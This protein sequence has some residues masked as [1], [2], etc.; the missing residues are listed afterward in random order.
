MWR[1]WAALCRCAIAAVCLATAVAQPAHADERILAA[2]TFTKGWATFGLALPQ[3]A[4]TSAV[5]VGALPTQTDVK[6][7]WPDG[8]IRFAVV[9][10]NVPRA[11]AL[12]I[13][14]GTPAAGRV[15][16]DSPAVAV[17]LTIG[18]RPY[19]ATLGPADAQGDLWLNGP[20][21]TEGRAVIAPGAHP[22]LRVVFDVRSYAGGGQRIDITTENCLDVASA[23][24]V[25]YDVAIAI[26][27]KPVFEQA[28]VVHK[29]LSRW[30]KVFTTG[31]LEESVVAPNLTSFA[32][33][34]ALPAYLPSIEQ[35]RRA[36]TGPGV[37]GS[38][39]GILSFGDLTVPMNGHS[40][41]PELAPYP[42]WT[43]Q[44]LVG[45][46][47][48]QRA[49]VLRH[50]EL[51]GSWG[52]HIKEP[53]GQS[54]VSIDKHPYYWLD[55]RW[56]DNRP[57]FE[58]PKNL[59]KGA[60]EPGDLAHQPSLAF[61][62]YLVT[63]DR[64]FADEVAYWANFCLIG[65]FASD[66]NRKGAQGLLI[67]NEVRGI[68]WGLRALGDAAAYLPDVSPLKA[69]FASKV[70]NNLTSLDKYATAYQSGPVQT[71]FPNRRPED[72]MAQYQ[73]YMWIS[74]W[75]QAYLAWGVDRVMQHGPITP[76]VNFANA[77]AA[78]R[79]RIA[80]LQLALFTDP[81]WPKDHDRAAPYLLAVGRWS[82]NRQLTY[83]ESLAQVATATFSVPKPGAPDFVRP[84]QGYYGPEARLLLT[85]CQSLGDRGA[86]ESLARLLSDSTDGVSTLDDLNKRSGWAIGRPDVS[87]LTKALTTKQPAAKPPA[88]RR[89]TRQ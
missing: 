19:V 75:E 1:S 9:T 41:R 6:V 22:F 31:G 52:V 12:P 79:N 71:L 5:R 24:E 86:S 49:Y 53:D 67:G 57:A 74:L 25:I 39:F 56:V 17:T 15:G 44:Y 61:V 36:L 89:A 54:L 40:G 55:R 20:L 42:D 70:W 2:N 38:G 83:F 21:V 85:M 7:R 33:A 45:G 51:A 29:Y 46:R 35:P 60:A 14:A 34:N 78:I 68:G 65:S 66:D 4:A 76:S 48:D 82:A 77:G 81:Q 37:S 59:M 23:D 72:S 32:L 58:G 16:T 50:G 18:G 11:G 10:T 13:V 63:G 8:S 88:V 43:A 30:R 64:F 69:Y 87:L 27:G 47:A 28:K 3:G 84:F 80:R 73:P 26:G 62:P